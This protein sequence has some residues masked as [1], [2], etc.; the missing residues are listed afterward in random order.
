MGLECLVISRDEQS[1]EVLRGAAEKLAICLEVCRG[2]RTGLEMLVSEKYDGVILDCDDLQGGLDLLQQLRKTTS[3]RTSVS[4]AMLN[5]STT[6]RNAFE[7]GANFVLQKPLLPLTTVR[8]F[9]AAFGQMTREKRRYFRVPVEMD[10]VLL[11]EEGKE[12]SG[13]ATNI[14]E[15]GM[16]VKVHGKLPDQPIS[17]ARFILPGTS[18]RLETAAD[19]AWADGSGRAGLRFVNLPQTSKDHLERWVLT[20]META[21]TV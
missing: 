21:G 1:L 4:F 19:V 20:H 17:L 6:T 16:A 9:S 13:A 11:F 2:A 8:C 14:S 18:N 7:R 12:V 10:V 5:G 3:N 15:G